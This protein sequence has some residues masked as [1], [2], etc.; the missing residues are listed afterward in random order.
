MPIG[1][2]PLWGI[3]GNLPVEHPLC[4]YT[5]LLPFV[6]VFAWGDFSVR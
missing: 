4:T 1:L 2:G 5:I 6:G 3:M